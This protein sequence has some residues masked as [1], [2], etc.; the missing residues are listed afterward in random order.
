V[1]GVLRSADA[2]DSRKIASPRLVF[3]MAGRSRLNVTCYLESDLNKARKIYSRKK[4]FRLM[5]QTLGCEV[6]VSIAHADQLAMV[7]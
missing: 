6:Q 1:L 4:K 2:L 5:E 3:A 7:A